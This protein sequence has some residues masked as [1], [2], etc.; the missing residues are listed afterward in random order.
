MEKKITIFFHVS[1]H[2]DHFK[3]IKVFSPRK[4]PETFGRGV[5][6]RGDHGD[7]LVQNSLHAPVHSDLWGNIRHFC[8]R[9]FF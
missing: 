5:L 6:P 7:P 4:K 3:A 8:K 1:E 9:D 2:V